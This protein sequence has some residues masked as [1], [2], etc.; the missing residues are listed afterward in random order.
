MSGGFDV[1]I[2]TWNDHERLVGA[3]ASA[4]AVPGVS[5][6]VVVDDGS[7][8]SVDPATLDDARVVLHRQANAGAP[9]ARQ[10]GI[11]LAESDYVVLLDSDDE[12]L[13]AA[14]DAVRAAREAGAAGVI[15]GRLRFEPDGGDTSGTSPCMRTCA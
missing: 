11:E 10:R 5:R 13:P 2:R 7:E 3:V 9:A 14:A 15:S 4:A 8:P 1:V 12:L 6:I